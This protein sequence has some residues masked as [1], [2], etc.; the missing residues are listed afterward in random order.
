[1]VIKH[2][3]KDVLHLSD[4][5]IYP[6]IKDVSDKA[7]IQKPFYSIVDIIE[8]Y[9]LMCFMGTEEIGKTSLSKKLSINFLDNGNKV[10]LLNGDDVC[11]TNPEDLIKRFLKKYKLKKIN[12][13]EYKDSILIID[14]FS[15]IAMLNKYI[16][17]F[18]E[19]MTIFFSKVIVIIGKNE[20]VQYQSKLSSSG[21]SFLEILPFGHK[22]RNE[23]IQKWLLINEENSDMAIS[24]E[25][26]SKVDHITSQFESIMKKNIMESKPIYLITIIQFLDGFSNFSDKFTLTSFGHC[27]QVLIMGML[28]KAKIDLKQDA[29]GV[30][31]FLG[32]LS[33]EFY[34]KDVKEISDIQFKEFYNQYSKRFNVLKN[35]K[36]KLLNSGIIY[37]SENYSIKFSQNYLYYFCCAKYIADNFSKHGNEINSLCEN[38]HNEDKANIL[39]FLVHHFRDDKILLNEVLTH[40]ICLMENNIAFYMTI[41]NNKKF[42]N[43]ID[44]NI[45]SIVLED[46]DIIEERNKILQNKEM[47]ENE[48]SIL[49]N[50][51][52]EDAKEVK[53]SI[54]NGEFHDNIQD[55]FSAL[56][57]LE[58]IG[59]I[60]KNRNSSIELDSL[61]ELLEISYDI[62]LKILGFYMELF[63]NNYDDLKE[64]IKDVIISNRNI[65][66]TK[67]I[68]E[69]A[70]N[71]IRIFCFN[72]CFHIIKLIAKNTAHSNLLENSR[73]LVENKD[74]PAYHLILLASQ[75]N[76]DYQ[77][78]KDLILDM[79]ENFRSNP[80]AYSLMRSL[81]VHH[82]YIY[83]LGYKDMQWICDKLDIKKEQIYAGKENG[84]DKLLQ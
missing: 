7:A 53:D 18:L 72:I 66:T 65:S 64:I 73:N 27:Y 58:V 1:M 22:K 6:D 4:I 23:F 71:L 47:L 55:V 9:Q 82:S 59:Q 11:S 26:L 46:K 80:L 68:T 84:I 39:I 69:E 21:F 52:E 76:V 38:I 83:D 57:S 20:I 61:N 81:I 10:I 29:D 44:S 79:L 77:L 28:N 8:K 36:D 63:S 56:K 5:Y 43:V 54:S 2:P 37:T 42:T 62:G 14:N 74:I 51:I 41:E 50:I 49:D 19:N 67:D 17:K 32:Y 70:E 30:L 40:S 25:I 31:N 35:I 16:S 75:L 24:N 60:A 33:F 34:K 78:P 13:K 3:K 45:K 48:N 15:N 12:S